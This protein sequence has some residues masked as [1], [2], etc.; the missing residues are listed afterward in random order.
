M[1]ETSPKGNSSSV[2][3]KKAN[4]T[5]EDQILADLDI[6]VNHFHSKC[7]GDSKSLIS[8]LDKVKR[9]ELRMEMLTKELE[10]LPPNKVKIAEKV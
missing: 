6:L 10:L 9:I 3:K 2:M 4:F 1:E 8:T 7:V 5:A